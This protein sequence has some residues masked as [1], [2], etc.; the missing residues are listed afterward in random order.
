[1]D[2]ILLIL[3]LLFGAGSGVMADDCSGG[4]VQQGSG[5]GN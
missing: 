4:T 3:A 2:S 5:S 1:M